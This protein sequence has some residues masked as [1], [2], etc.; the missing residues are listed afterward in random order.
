MSF[1]RRSKDYIGD[2]VGV[3]P[4]TSIPPKAF[5][6]P[7]TLPIVPDIPIHGSL[8]PNKDDTALKFRPSLPPSLGMIL[9]D[10]I[11]PSNPRLSKIS[12][13]PNPK[14]Q[15]VSQRVFELLAEAQIALPAPKPEDDTR[16]YFSKQK[17]SQ[18]ATS[19]G[20]GGKMTRKAIEEAVSEAR[21]N[22]KS[23]R[24]WDRGAQIRNIQDSFAY[25]EKPSIP[26]HPTK[27]DENGNPLECEYIIPLLPDFT[28]WEEKLV[29]VNLT[30]PGKKDVGLML[31]NSIEDEGV[32][33]TAGLGEF[34][35]T[36]PVTPQERVK[37]H[38]KEHPVEEERESQPSGPSTHRE[39]EAE[40][41]EDSDSDYTHIS[42]GKFSLHTAP[43]K[44][45]S[46]L[47]RFS[48]SI[49]EGISTINGQQQESTRV[50]LYRPISAKYTAQWRA[51]APM[52]INIS[53]RPLETDE[54][55]QGKMRKHELMDEELSVKDE[56]VMELV[57]A[58]KEAQE[59]KE[60]EEQLRLEEE[61]FLKSIHEKHD[62]EEDEE[63]TDG[64]FAA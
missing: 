44:D 24:A 43:L 46:F 29:H 19:D 38:S 15:D 23:I 33:S 21:A 54:I 2:F 57:D 61:Q 12:L 55:E 4:L 39:E 6:V 8:L 51:H 58:E 17:F 13:N 63:D 27:K 50:C 5:P 1:H 64:L 53:E 22:L 36:F 45:P 11:D 60:K 10:E 16:L 25:A 31:F 26:H 48:D 9:E 52:K 41:G 28:H 59:E 34:F 62:K 18:P 3:P 35:L 56:E 30:R 42:H 47:L 14:R 20:S 32:S 49:E 40:D 7:P 37:I